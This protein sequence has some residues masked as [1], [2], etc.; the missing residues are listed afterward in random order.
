MASAT[1]RCTWYWADP[2]R[3]QREVSGHRHDYVGSSASAEGN[4]TELTLTI[5]FYQHF[6]LALRLTGRLIEPA[7]SKRLR[8]GWDVLP[9]TGDLSGNIPAS[10]W[11]SASAS[12]PDDWR[13]CRKLPHAV[14]SRLF[15]GHNFTSLLHFTSLHFL[16]TSPQLCETNQPSHVPNMSKTFTGE[17]AELC[18]PM[19]Q[20]CL[21]LERR[22]P[23]LAL[24][25]G[26]WVEHMLPATSIRDTH[27]AKHGEPHKS[28][29]VGTSS[30]TTQQ[31]LGGPITCAH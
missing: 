22:K 9:L 12:L 7:C 10:C 21:T 3:K 28:T 25:I 1:S 13:T 31:G 20:Q 23:Q 26:Y 30:M 8:S 17:A 27:I 29:C 24:Q 5:V 19:L 2:R 11:M 18:N 15:Q 16:P 6:S 4:W 14:L